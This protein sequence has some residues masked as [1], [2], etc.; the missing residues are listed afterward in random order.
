[1]SAPESGS[2]DALN[3]P[4]RLSALHDSGL[5]DS[6][7]EEDFDRVTRL[8]TRIIGVPVSLVS[9]VDDNRQFFKSQVGLGAPYSETRETPLTHSFCQHVVQTADVLAVTNAPQD[10]R[11]CDNLAI[12]DLVVIAYLGVPLN[13]PD[14]TV[15]GSL[16]AIDSK[17]REWQPD[18]ITALQDLA[19]IVMD[20]IALRSEVSRR[21]EAER[22]QQLVIGELHHRVKNTLA[23]VQA[24]VGLSLRHATSL[25]AVRES[26]VERIGALARTHDQLVDQQWSSASLR[27]L[28]STE[29]AAHGHGDRIALSGPDLSLPPQLAVSVGM[30]SHELMTNAS[31]HGALSTPDGRITVDWTTEPADDG[32]Q[33]RLTWL[34][35]GGPLVTKPAET[36]FGSLLLENVMSRQMSGSVT[37]DYRPEGLE[38]TI[39][40]PLPEAA[41]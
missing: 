6:P 19:R 33:L 11:V 37:L 8:A 16:C 3:D 41:G 30:C 4:A 28:L 22:Q 25:P 38:A 40:I 23:M 39:L 17:P 14:G 32:E 1:M 13:R 21:T 31:K 7:P 9:L 35:S 15:L 5:M 26:I 18:D 27:D 29:L 20:Q 24:M 36:G 12:R 10:E 2:T 34:E